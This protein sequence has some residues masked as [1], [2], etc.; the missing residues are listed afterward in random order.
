MTR[1]LHTGDL[2]DLVGS[3]PILRSLGGGEIVVSESRFTDRGR[4]PRETM[5]GARY[6]AIRPL[7]LAQPYVTAVSWQDEPQGVTH[8]LSHFRQLPF[9]KG[10][11][12]ATW[13]ARYVG[14]EI[15]LEPWLTVP[16]FVQHDKTVIS[17]SLRYHNFFF[18]WGELIYKAAPVVFVGLE[19]E[20]VA[21][22]Q[23]T[24]WNMPFQATKDLLELAQVIAGAKLFLGNQ[25]APFWIAAGLGISLIQ[26]SWIGDLNSIVERPNAIYTATDAE[27]R[28]LIARLYPRKKKVDSRVPV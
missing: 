23:E 5:R 27:A 25:S 8:D 2:G 12:L 11:N 18:P 13:Q 17:R 14:V 21:F 10:E 1:L 3:L 16:D 19:S 26:E 6:E 4:A 22:Q 24:K 28:T 7:L 15:D 9:K 20:H